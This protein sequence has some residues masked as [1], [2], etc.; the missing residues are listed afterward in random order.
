MKQAFA[1]AVA[2]MLAISAVADDGKPPSTGLSVFANAGGYW[3]SSA[4]ADFYSG[5]PSSLNPIDRVLH[6]NLYGN[7]IWSHL[8]SQGVLS[9]SAVGGENQLSVEE[10][11]TMSYRTSYQIGLGL[12]YDYA[13]GFGWLLRFDIAKLQALGAFNLSTGGSAVLGSDQ[14]V[15]CGIVGREDRLNI[16]LAITK[17]IPL[18]NNLEMEL[19]LGAS[20][21]NTKVKDN[22]IEVAGRY[23][24]ILDV[25][26]GQSP[27]VGVGQYEYINQGRLGY[28]IF[29]SLLVGYRLPNVGAMKIGYTVYQARICFEDRKVW[30]WQHMLGVRIEIN[31]F[32]FL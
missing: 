16:D 12:R 28:G 29:T 19:D 27:D 20:L 9:P 6:S 31:N 25:T 14:Y 18:G 15:R 32:S 5:A 22:T 24:Q 23:W 21:I 26:G 3:A 11:P 8:V 1:T 7:Q 2:L 30:G 13:S 10:Y 4:A 17:T